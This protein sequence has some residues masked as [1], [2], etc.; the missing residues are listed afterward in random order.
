S[1]TIRASCA[2]DT[3]DSPRLIC[4]LYCLGLR[5]S[6]EEEK[7]QRRNRRV[8][9]RR[10]PC[11]VKLL[12]TP[13]LEAQHLREDEPGRRSATKL[14]LEIEIAGRLTGAVADDEA[15]PP[16]AD[17]RTH[18]GPPGAIWKAFTRLSPA[19]VSPGEPERSQVTEGSS[20]RQRF[21]LMFEWVSIAALI[22]YGG[23]IAFSRG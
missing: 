9:G 2:F 12:R 3:F 6:F 10:H 4:L 17:R 11:G 21:P 18:H 19:R 1:E 13:R 22:I 7:R 15:N 20:E 16:H 5:S 14:I 23:Q 8:V